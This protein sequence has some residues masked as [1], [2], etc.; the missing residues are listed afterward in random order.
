MMVDS[1]NEISIVVVISH[2]ATPY[3]FEPKKASSS[4]ESAK[5]KAVIS[6]DNRRTVDNEYRTHDNSWCVCG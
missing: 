1:I 3:N 6:D 2:M 5:D 4:S